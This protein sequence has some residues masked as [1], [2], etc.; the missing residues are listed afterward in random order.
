MKQRKF[1]GG[2]N[3]TNLPSVEVG[4]EKIVIFPMVNHINF[5]SIRYRCDSVCIFPQ[6]L[7]PA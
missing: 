5:D 3:T 7:P 1:Y 6:M 2:K 4:R